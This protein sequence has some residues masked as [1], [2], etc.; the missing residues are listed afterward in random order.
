MIEKKE[1]N[2]LFDYQNP[3]LSIRQRVEDLLSRMTLEEKAAQT[4]MLRGVEYAT[5]PSQKHN[6]SVEVDTDFD[7]TKLLQDFGMDGF[8]FVHD[9][10]ATPVAFNKIQKYFIEH[11]RLGIPVIFTSEALHGVSGLRGKVFPVPLNFGA[12]FDPE[13]IHKVGEA[14]ATETRAL[15]MHEILAPNLDVAREPGSL[16]PMWPLGPRPSSCRSA[17]PKAS[18]TAS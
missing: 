11:S 10:Y 2:Q 4:C 13:L 7:E 8:G 14:I 5:K 12:T 15:G 16:K 6:C 3:K 17:P 1:G 18:M 9:M